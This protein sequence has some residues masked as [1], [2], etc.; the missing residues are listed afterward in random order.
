MKP[1]PLPAICGLSLPVPSVR[2]TSLP[3]TS[4]HGA[5]VPVPSLHGMPP[6]VL[7]PHGTSQ[8]TP[9]RRVKAWDAMPAPG[10]ACLQAGRRAGRGCP[11]GSPTLGAVGT[12]SGAVR[13]EGRGV[14]SG[15]RRSPRSSVRPAS[16]GD[17]AP[18]CAPANSL[19]AARIPACR[20]RGRRRGQSP[21]E[22][23]GCPPSCE[24]APLPA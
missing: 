2:R 4:L 15:R 3:T 12:G 7:S 20:G 17:G 14:N 6:P 11:A 10:R 22:E 24:S 16:E 5:S 18:L 23:V 8:A 21:R 13:G 9:P 19:T 1:R